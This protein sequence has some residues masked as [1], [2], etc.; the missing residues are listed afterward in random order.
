VKYLSIDLET[1]G[2]DWTYCQVLQVGAVYDD[3]EYPFDEGRMRATAFDAIVTHDK[4]VGQPYALHMNAHLLDEI[5]N[6]EKGRSTYRFVRPEDVNLCLGAWAEH[7]TGMRGGPFS[8]AGKNFAGFDR[9]FLELLP[10]WGTQFRTR[11]RVIDPGPLYYRPGDKELPGLATCLERAGLD[12]TVTHDAVDD[13]VQVVKLI[14]KHYL[15]KV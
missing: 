5:A 4:I 7:Q 9:R 3:L 10:G 15:G 12:P 1:S 14:R 2:L 11:S 8:V 6:R 13:A